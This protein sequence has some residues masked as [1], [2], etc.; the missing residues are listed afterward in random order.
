MLEQFMRLA[1]EQS[2]K[3]NAERLKVG[4]C[5]VSNR[6]KVISWGYNGVPGIFKD[7][8]CEQKLEDGELVTSPF[9]VHAEVR[10]ISRVSKSYN[11][12]QHAI[13]YVTAS[14]CIECAKLIIESGI[15]K[16]IYLKKYVSKSNGDGLELLKK[17]GVKT[18]QFK[19]E[20]KS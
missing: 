14:P 13:L 1:I 9:V 12:T 3:S 20:I 15:K 10:A 4:C 17:C 5:I 11:S 19:G 16:V 2:K 6:N 18:E 7:Q 8:N